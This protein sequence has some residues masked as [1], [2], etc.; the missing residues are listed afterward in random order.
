MR[1]SFRLATTAATR[2]AH[3]AV[4]RR[5]LCLV[6]PAQGGGWR[7]RY[8]AGVIVSPTAAGAPWDVMERDTVDFFLHDYTPQAGDVVFDVGAGWGTE[9][10]TLSRLVGPG[11]RVI[12]VEAHP[13]TCELLRRTCDENGLDNVT[14]VQAA[15]ADEVGELAISDVE[16][17]R[18]ISNTVMDGSGDHVVPALTLDA[19][20]DQVDVDRIDLLKMNIEGAERLA[21]Q[22]MKRSAPLIR[23]LAI[24][25]HDFRAERG[26]G[27]FFRTRAEVSTALTDMGFELRSRPDDVRPWVRYFLYGKPTQ[28]ME[29]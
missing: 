1:V 27:E 22:G 28:V 3:L 16:D 6:T 2:M 15:L 21:V 9:T 18:N 5:S 10:V 23:N 7:H 26:D 24:S 25:C 11:G 20:L 17:E 13:W 14:V 19:L 4:R 29:P 12:A 8:R